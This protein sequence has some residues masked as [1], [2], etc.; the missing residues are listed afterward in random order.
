[1]SPGLLAVMGSFWDKGW[2][3]GKRYK[4]DHNESMNEN[5]NKKLSI[6]NWSFNIFELSKLIKIN[7]WYFFIKQMNN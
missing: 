2:V 5:N 7:E 6:A 1:M 4:V 3:W